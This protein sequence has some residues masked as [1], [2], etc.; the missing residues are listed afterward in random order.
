M[1]ASRSMVGNKKVVLGLLFFLFITTHTHKD[2]K[3]IHN[4]GMH[5]PG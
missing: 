3:Y 5:I 4:E 1:V 2:S